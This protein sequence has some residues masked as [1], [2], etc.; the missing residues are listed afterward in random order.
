MHLGV[1]HN[2]IKKSDLHVFAALIIFRSQINPVCPFV[3][4]LLAAISD[5]VGL[6]RVALLKFI[7]PF[8][9]SE[10]ILRKQQ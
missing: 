9:E 8:S 6:A 4:H 10:G 1:H 7:I 3:M 2:L 5:I